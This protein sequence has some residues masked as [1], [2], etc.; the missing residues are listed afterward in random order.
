MLIERLEAALNSERANQTARQPPEFSEPSMRLG[1]GAL[2]ICGGLA[3]LFLSFVE[4]KT[5]SAVRLVGVEQIFS[6]TSGTLKVLLY[7]DHYSLE[8][9]A[10]IFALGGV[11][12]AVQAFRWVLWRWAGWFISEDI[13]RK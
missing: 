1:V 6:P 13:G 5:Q 4:S 3:D 9:A 7:L 12:F 2:I 10:A 8:F 11:M